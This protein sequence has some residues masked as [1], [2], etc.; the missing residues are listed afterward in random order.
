MKNVCVITGGGSGMGL[1]TAKLMGKDNT[2]LIA[3]RSQK[4]LEAALT[5]LRA[6]GVEAEAFACDVAIRESVD[7]LAARA[8]ELGPV[9]A[10]V[11]SA[12]LSP[13]MGEPRVIME[14]NALG[15]VNVNEA[16]SA[17]MAKGSCIVDVS[18]MAG[19]MMP[20]L[21]LPTKDYK[22]SRTDKELFL[23]R[24]MAR[25]NLFPKSKQAGVAY[26]ISKNFVIW[27]AKT[28]A[29]QRGPEGIRVLS[30][31]PGSFETPMA[32]LEKEATAGYT[33]QS[34]LGRIGRVEEIANLLAFCVSDKA[35]YLTGVDILCDGGCM[36][37]GANPLKDK[38]KEVTRGLRGSTSPK[39]TAEAGRA[40]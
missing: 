31:S 16:L 13:H 32:E 17:V 3:G 27:Y 34:P 38:W 20:G 25:V 40:A 26:G 18:S 9:T 29:V 19:H 23:H 37:V 24:M 22:L 35:G 28:D 1:A 14:G 2:I 7:R 10:V 21:I 12:G 36:A 4:K 33:E 8:K 30:V 11:H 39:P 5:E 15:T 6:E